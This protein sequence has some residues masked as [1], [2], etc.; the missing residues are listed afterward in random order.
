MSTANERSE[1]ALF[2]RAFSES[3]CERSEQPDP[4]KGR[5]EEIEIVEE[6]VG[7]D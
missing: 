6:A 4:E 5:S 3:G 2:D 7:D 1:F